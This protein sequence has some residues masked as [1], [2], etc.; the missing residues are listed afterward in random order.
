MA[1][2]HIGMLAAAGGWYGV[3]E[4][5]ADQ[6]YD[7]VGESASLGATVGIATAGLGYAAYK[8][9]DYATKNTLNMLKTAP[10]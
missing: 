6:Q 1:V 2:G 10:K 8:L 7:S 4:S 3:A 5:N 9:T